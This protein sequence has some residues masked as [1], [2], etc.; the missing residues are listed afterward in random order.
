M[1]QKINQIDVQYDF[2][3]DK[4]FGLVYINHCFPRYVKL[5]IAIG[6]IAGL[7]V[8]L[9]FDTKD[10]PQR[11]IS[12]GG[13]VGLI[14]FGLLISKYPGRVLWS[15]VLWGIGIQFVMGL[16][17]LRWRGGQCALE[18]ISTKV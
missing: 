12:A 15:Q 13:L 17:V 6:L 4:W 2:G 11:L 8:F 3:C 10:Q 16:A 18:C 5:I 7:G 14:L 1:N 9:Y